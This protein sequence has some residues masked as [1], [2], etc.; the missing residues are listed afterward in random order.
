[1]SR[2]PAP[3]SYNPT[4]PPNPYNSP[5]NLGLPSM[6][7]GGSG[8][9]SFMSLSST[10]GSS[11]NSSSQSSLLRYPTLNNGAG[12]GNGL[13]FL[14][15][16]HQQQGGAGGL[17]NYG[18]AFSTAPPLMGSHAASSPYMRFGPPSGGL[19]G[20]GYPGA[21]A[22][23]GGP[24]LLRGDHDRPRV[25]EEKSRPVRSPL[26]EEFRADKVR[27]WAVRVSSV[28]LSYIHSLFFSFIYC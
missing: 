1:M 17:S 2:G 11:P 27:R 4:P 21:G 14:L 19:G 13:D 6:D 26:L 23:A 28:S 5:F 8:G 7:G 20:S 12:L 10:T 16:H 25:Y 3:Y 15:P 24:Y 22:G 18:M 9:S